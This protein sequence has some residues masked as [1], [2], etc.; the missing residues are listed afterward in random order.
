VQDLDGRD[1][2]RRRDQIVH[3]RGGDELSLVVVNK[4]LVQRRG[5][6]LSNTSAHLALDNHRVDHNPAVLRDHV[7]VYANVARLRVDLYHHPVRS[8]RERARGIE[9]GACLK[10]PRLPLR[11]PLGLQIGRARYRRHLDIAIRGSANIDL[12]VLH[13]EVPRSRL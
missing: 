5:D 1:L 2:H 7:A 10:A 8:V 3:K 13:L 6:P 11:Q 4:L 9:A 12:T